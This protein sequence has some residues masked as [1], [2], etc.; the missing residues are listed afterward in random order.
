M[1]T[2]TNRRQFLKYACK[3]GIAL[4]LATGLRPPTAVVH[5]SQNIDESVFDNPQVWE[6]VRNGTAP[7]WVAGQTLNSFLYHLRFINLPPNL[8]NYLQ[9]AGGEWKGLLQAKGL[10]DTIPPQI[11]AGG[12]K[13]ILRFLNG[14]DWSH[15]IPRSQGGP[16]T[17][18]N[19]IFEL[20]L[21]NRMRGARTMTR[22][23]IAAA[24]AV[25]RSDIVVSV[26]RQ[27]LGAMVKGAIIGVIFSGLIICLECGL[28]Y[29]EGKITW[30]KMVT[31]V[32]RSILLAGGLAFIITG[33][34]VGLGLLFPGLIAILVVPMFIIQIVGLVF[35]AEHAISL[36]GRYWE[37][38]EKHCLIFEACLILRITEEKLR[39]I[40]DELK[41]S[42]SDKIRE[43]MLSIAEW[44]GWE[45]AKAIV[46]GLQDRL[47][48][49]RFGVWSA[50]QSQLVARYASDSVSP[51]NNWGYASDQHIRIGSVDLPELNLPE[52]IIGMEE[53]KELIANTIYFDFKKALSTISLLEEHLRGC[54][55]WVDWEPCL[56]PRG[57]P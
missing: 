38:L 42:V 20:R 19:G 4:S 32:M 12:P 45:R 37:L 25:I 27:T 51:L 9:R 33:L 46:E 48:P 47:G 52:I 6:L 22:G 54:L 39:E 24:R 50:T 41:G 11:R 5:G 1:L 14:K 44:F 30:E 16:T 56:L 15:H 36:S 43:W 53:M 21:L 3:T 13:E 26:I 49:D 8:T 18:E 55:N 28:L 40:I 35:L 17:G 57:L 31:K 34:L 23:E 2:S 10:W 7:L 29:A